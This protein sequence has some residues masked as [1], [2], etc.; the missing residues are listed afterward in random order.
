MTTTIYDN[1]KNPWATIGRDVQG[2]SNLEEVMR[3]ANLDWNVFKTPVQ[4][5]GWDIPNCFSMGRYV[6]ATGGRSEWKHFGIVTERYKPVQNIDAFR[7]LE[8]IVGEELEYETAGCIKWGKQTFVS[9]KMKKQW[10]VGDD[11]IDNYLLCSNSHDGRSSLRYAITPVRVACQ[12]ALYGAL[13]K[14]KRV[15]SVRHFNNAEMRLEEARHALG[16]SVAYMENFV[17]Y[18]N[19]AIDTK[20]TDEKLEGLYDVLFGEKES[21]EGRALT[22]RNRNIEKLESCLVAPDLTVYN[23]SVWQV[24]NAVSDFETHVKPTTSAMRENLAGRI[25]DGNMSLYDKTVK[26]F[27]EMLAV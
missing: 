23:G 1:R 7:F 16:L 15:Y 22:I 6:A 2:A 4:A 8:G 5:G 12:N 17:E 10:M 24:L 14:A 13:K 20:C 18:G 9:C 26:Y 3:S 21:K 27:S 11:L 19:R 25:L